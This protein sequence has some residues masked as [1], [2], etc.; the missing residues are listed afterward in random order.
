MNKH[1]DDGGKVAHGKAKA[2]K[3][4]HNWGSMH[5]ADLTKKHDTTEYKV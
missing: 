1:N 3:V 4:N 2:G 5:D